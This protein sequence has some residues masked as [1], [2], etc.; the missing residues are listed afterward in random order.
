MLAFRLFLLFL[1]V[2]SVLFSGISLMGSNKEKM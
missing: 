1:A 2:I